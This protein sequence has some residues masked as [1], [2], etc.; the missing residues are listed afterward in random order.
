MTALTQK[1]KLHNALAKGQELTAKQITAR[2]K[3]AS[4]TKIISRLR[5]DDKLPVL[6]KRVTNTKGQE[7]F[8]YAM[9]TSK[10]RRATAAA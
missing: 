10:A 8:K 9:G 1:Q 6:T 4:P 3:I 7:V 2:F 5:H